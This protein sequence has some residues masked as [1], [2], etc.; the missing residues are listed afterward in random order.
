M[1]R[2][3]EIKNEKKLNNEKNRGKRFTTTLAG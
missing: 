1:T 3:M 2:K